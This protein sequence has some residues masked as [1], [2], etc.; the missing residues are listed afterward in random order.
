M[1]GEGEGGRGKGRGG[2]DEAASSPPC[3]RGEGEEEDGEGEGEDGE[4]EEEDGL[5]QQVV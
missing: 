3:W 2:W 5:K 4:G 1:E